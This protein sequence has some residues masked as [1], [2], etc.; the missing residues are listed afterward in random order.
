M[1]RNKESFFLVV[2]LAV[3][4]FSAEAA[5][6]PVVAIHTSSA[7]AAGWP[8]RAWSYWH[9][10]GFLKAALQA[11]GTLATEV[12][13]AQID[14][15]FLL[16]SGAPRFPI[17]ISFGNECVSNATAAAITAYVSAGGTLLTSGSSF[18]KDGSCVPRQVNG[19]SA[20]ALPMG[21]VNNGRWTATNAATRENSSA[22]SALDMSGVPSPSAI[23][24]GTPTRWFLPRAFDV[25]FDRE[26][27]NGPHWVWSASAAV[28]G[29]AQ[30]ALAVARDKGFFEPI[31]VSPF[32]EGYE[33][34][35]AD[36]DGDGKVDW[37]GRHTTT[38]Q[39]H[40]GLSL[41]LE[42][43]AP[44]YWGIWPNTLTFMLADISNDGKADLVGRDAAGLVTTAL[45]TGVAFIPAGSSGWN[46]A[47]TMSLA[48][49]NGDGRADLVGKRIDTSSTNAPVDVQVSLAQSNPF[50]PFP[51]ST[52]WVMWKADRE[53]VLGDLD[54]D[55]K[56]DLVGR[57]PGGI[58]VY[59]SL[60]NG[61]G[62]DTPAI[63]TSW[64]TS[65]DLQLGDVDGNGR[66]DIVGRCEKRL[67]LQACVVDEPA[68]PAPWW[69][70]TNTLDIQ[71]GLS[72][73]V[74]SGV[75]IGVSSSWN[76]WDAP[77]DRTKEEIPYQIGL[78][79]MVLGDI[80]GDGR[81]DFLGRMTDYLPGNGGRAAQI[82]ALVSSGSTSRANSSGEA[83]LA[84]KTHGAGE[85][86]YLAEMQPIVCYGADTSCQTTYRI[87]RR[88]IESAAQ[89][90]HVPVVRSAPWPYSQ[91]VAFIYRHDHVLNMGIV[92]AEQAL[93][94]RGEYY[95]LPDCSENSETPYLTGF[96]DGLTAGVVYGAHTTCHYLADAYSYA[97]SKNQIQGTL[98]LLEGQFASLDPRWS[99]PVTA[100]VAPGHGAIT[101]D[102]IRAIRD[103]G[104]LTTGEQGFGPFPSFSLDPANR[105]QDASDWT[106]RTLLQLPVAG[107][108]NNRNVAGPSLP[109]D[110]FLPPLP[111]NRVQI[112]MAYAVGG[113]IN[114]Y[115]HATA[116]NSPVKGATA[117]RQ[118]LGYVF[119]GRPKSIWKTTS[120]E[121]RHWE[122]KRTRKSLSATYTAATANL[123]HVISL[124]VSTAAPLEPIDGG[125]Q[126]G[127]S[128]YAIRLYLPSTLLVA[129]QQQVNIELDGVASTAYRIVDDEL[130]IRVG[131][132]QNVVVELGL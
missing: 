126:P 96:S 53:F 20:F 7:S 71:V 115:D 84:R 10:S 76:L 132:S 25:S 85:F 88:T 104:I 97:V 101:R 94:V 128:E 39:V 48:D 6:T 5:P 29:G 11:D 125:A 80:N 31:R 87:V 117:A 70:G 24:P 112:D 9:P 124:T 57:D 43:K 123:P 59:A 19:A 67:A 82:V 3:L 14:G 111:E 15:G 75:S 64:R 63:M 42:F 122:L 36:V 91:D 65:Y 106:A 108:I 119:S 49:V 72:L 60:S 28:S 1:Q 61:A 73:S 50:D 107:H 121:I 32:A 120:P 79:P 30:V 58:D 40:V 95:I 90:V 16:A 62:F 74:P 23:D 54:G 118:A 41:G 127:E 18:T 83:L 105:L 35:F 114:V 100:F 77:M 26:L 66:A 68:T 13:D 4:C 99:G 109:E 93:G 45:S 21:L 116:E 17:V 34:L 89:R 8:Y 52:G 2:L 47:Y 129:A 131:A 56:A 110:P 27:R 81:E 33:V 44:V 130:V 37:V 69:G 113:L 86:V 55:G 98:S 46:T 12:N 78:F 102:S 38:G 51:Q 103:S 92:A 22:D